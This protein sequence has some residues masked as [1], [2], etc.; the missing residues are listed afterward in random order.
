[1]LSLYSCHQTD[2]PFCQ[3][4]HFATL[5]ILHST[6]S[7]FFKSHLILCTSAMSPLATALFFLFANSLKSSVTH[8][9]WVLCYCFAWYEQ[10]N[11]SEVDVACNH[12]HF[13]IYSTFQ[14]NANM[15]CVFLH[16][17]TCENIA[18]FF[19]WCYSARNNARKKV[20]LNFYTCDRNYNTR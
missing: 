2:S 20:R 3:S 5:C 18:H 13:L 8:V 4:M 1:M 9:V 15:A 12:L 16:V 19:F 10:V 14:L 17:I 6:P 11:I 7:F